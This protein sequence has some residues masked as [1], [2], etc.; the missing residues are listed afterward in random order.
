MNKSIRALIFFLKSIAKI[1]ELFLYR[2]QIPVIVKQLRKKENIR[3]L[4][5]L[6]DVSLWK[7]E[8]LYREML[9][10]PRFSPILG[11]CLITSDI[12]SES[13]R[14]Y[15]ALKDYLLMKGY[16]YKEIFDL[17]KDRLGADIVFFQQP[18]ENVISPNV[19]YHSLIRSKTLICDVHYSMRTLAITKQ[20]RWVIDESLYRYCW[21]MY[22]ENSLTAEFGKLSLLKGKNIVITGMPI[23][24]ELLKESKQFINPWKKQSTEKKKIIYAPHHTI[25][26][27]GNLINLSCFLDVCDFMLE[28]AEKYADNIQFA[29]KPHP[30]LKKKLF[31]YWGDEKTN[32]YYQRWASMENTQLSEGEYISLFAY[33]DGMIHDCDS[34]TL[35]YT[36]TKKPALFLVSPSKES[37]R[38]DDLNKFGQIAYDL[39][40]KGFTKDDIESFIRKII[41]EEDTLKLERESFYNTY[42]L[43]PYGNT[44]SQ[45]IISAILGEKQYSAQL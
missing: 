23:Q 40:D 45:N 43:P 24:D 29:F 8:G 16:S 42:L 32:A 38:R 20:N 3:V 31:E 41:S 26:V 5:V 6:S 7:T 4:F 28:M 35:E 12:P 25:P 17:R 44:A 37:E 14:K 13:I 27:T 10:H 18:Y 36:F 22:V 1:L 11:T 2:K 34:F 21:Q 33:S 39:H 30:F 19:F 9:V 15:N